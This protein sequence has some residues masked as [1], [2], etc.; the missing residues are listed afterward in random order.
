MS[1]WDKSVSLWTKRSRCSYRKYLAL[2]PDNKQ[3][4]LSILSACKKNYPALAISLHF[5]PSPSFCFFSTKQA[6]K[7]HQ[8]NNLASAADLVLA[9]SQFDKQEFTIF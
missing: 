9:F 3:N 2:A 1:F 7:S 6:N 4:N 8:Y 5:S